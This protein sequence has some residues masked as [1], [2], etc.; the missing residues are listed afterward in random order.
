MSRAWNRAL[1]EEY[2][3][4]LKKCS[5]TL[6]PLITKAVK[7]TSEDEL[8]DEPLVELALIAVDAASAAASGS[9]AGLELLKRLQDRARSDKI[10]KH[11]SSLS[12]Q[13]RA[14]RRNPG[15]AQ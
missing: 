14:G 3:H 12:W 7:M 8:L 6:H 9:A 11:T 1:D 2:P 13:Q 15:W 5:Y 4:S 10:A